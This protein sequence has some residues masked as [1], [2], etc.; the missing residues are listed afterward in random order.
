MNRLLL[1]NQELWQKLCAMNKVRYQTLRDHADKPLIT[2]EDARNI[3]VSEWQKDL[4]KRIAV[5]IAGF[6]ASGKTTVAKWLVQDI[7]DSSH[8]NVAAHLPMDGFHFSNARL[9]AAGLEPVKGRT[10]TYDVNAYIDKVRD[11]KRSLNSLVMAPDYDREN[12]E[13]SDNAIAIGPTIR[14]LITEGIYVGYKGGEWGTLRPL[15]DI[16]LYIDLSPEQCAD[17]ICSRNLKVGRTSRVIEH[18]L[19][20]DFGFMEVTIQILPEVDY[21]LSVDI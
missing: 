19:S 18:K 21:I 20:N 6:P 12:H 1:D 16:L 15:L 5:G 17:R 10:D 13:V 4:S 11:F 14:I 3:V 8:V 7:N 2:L 9:S